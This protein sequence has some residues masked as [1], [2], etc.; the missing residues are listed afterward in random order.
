MSSALRS[1]Q[2]FEVDLVTV[3]GSRFQPTG[4]PDIGAAT[5][6]RPV[7]RNGEVAFEPALLVESAQSMANRLEAVAWDTAHDQPVNVLAGLPYVRVLAPDGTFITS[8]RVEAHRLASAFIK[9]ATL[10]GEDMK[11][12][13][14]DRLDLKD[15]RPIAAREVARAVARLDPMCLLHGVFFAES[16]KVWPGQPKIPRAVTGFIEAHDVRPAE[17]GGVKR[18]VV[19]HSLAEG[20][21]GTSEGYGSV[22]YHRTEWTAARIVA[23]FSIDRDQIRTYG[24]DDAATELLIA[25]A[26]WEI[27]TLLDGGLRLRTACDLQPANG[28]LIDLS[29]DPLLDADALAAKIRDLRADTDAFGAGDPIEVTWAPKRKGSQTAASADEG[30]EE[31]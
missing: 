15:D 12:V 28:D 30:D 2:L 29:G 27:R 8:S 1:R 10:D 3:S 7:H 14:R 17:S 26:Q 5:F 4:F 24:L 6:D 31:E 13:I 19:R 23:Y 18:D 22:P 25:V 21:G 9:D 16:A 11:A 20:Q